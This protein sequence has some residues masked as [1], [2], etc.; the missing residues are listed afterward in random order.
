MHYRSPCLQ[1][2]FLSCLNFSLIFEDPLSL[3]L[4]LVE[5]YT[6]VA[7]IVTKTTLHIRS[8]YHAGGNYRIHDLFG[9][10]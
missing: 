2:A 8:K 4:L 10:A 5:L 9:G 3:G 7:Q 1:L 6:I